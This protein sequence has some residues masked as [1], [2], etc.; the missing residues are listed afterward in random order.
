MG[1]E[2]DPEYVI[3]IVKNINMLP[4]LLCNSIILIAWIMYLTIIICKMFL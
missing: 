2:I 4:L 1:D 3:Y